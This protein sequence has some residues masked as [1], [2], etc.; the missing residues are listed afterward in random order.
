MIT[1]EDGRRLGVDPAT[2]EVVNDF[3]FDGFDS[4]PGQ[5][6]F[7]AINQADVGTYSIDT[8]GTGSGH[9]GIHVYSA[10]WNRSL[11]NHI[12]V[13]GLAIPGVTADHD[14]TLTPDGSVGFGPMRGDF[15]GNCQLDCTDVA[16]LQQGARGGLFNRKFDVNADGTVNSS[17][18]FA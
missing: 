7:L 5:P 8:I 18:A 14:F 11:S 10:D 9:Y 12:F 6:R 17:D 15:D 3:G 2:G 1:S 16:L 4:G 13:D